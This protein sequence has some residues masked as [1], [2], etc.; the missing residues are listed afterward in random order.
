MKIAL[1]YPVFIVGL[2]VTAI[3]LVA[4]QGEGTLRER[5]KAFA[6]GHH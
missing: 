6:G 2:L 1:G 5:I 3:I 4:G